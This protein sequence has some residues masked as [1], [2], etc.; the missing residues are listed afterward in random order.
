MT[1]I[2]TGSTGFVGRHLTP[3]LPGA[4]CLTRA[5]FTQ[6]DNVLRTKCSSATSFI[7]LAGRAHKQGETADM[8]PLYHVE[9]VELTR[10]CLQLAKSC[11]ATHFIFLSTIGVHGS[12][13]IDQAFSEH[14]P[15]LP[16][17]AYAETKIQA[18]Q[19]VIDFCT[20]NTMAW[21]ILRPPL[22]YG[23][24]APGN[25]GM[26]QK[27]L[28]TGMPLPFGAFTNRRSLISV[29]NLCSVI[30]HCLN[31][32]K[33]HN[34]IY[35]LGDGI[36]RSTTE[37]LRLLAQ[38]AQLPARLIPVPAFL[39]KIAAALT[40]QNKRLAPL[41]EDLRVDNSKSVTQLGWIPVN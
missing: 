21:T 38:R 31:N 23:D 9:N 18:E 25:I 26:L 2:I 7:H 22:V 20:K 5:D 33:S 27:L 41:W 1:S 37:L 28:R 29:E 13:T 24:N 32:E 15:L 3:L 19:E 36:D 39:L 34:Q 12:K 4:V 10:R 16:H 40:G 14:S 17:N 11:G 6:S 35:V 8:L 30:L